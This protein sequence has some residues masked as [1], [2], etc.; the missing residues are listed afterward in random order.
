VPQSFVEWVEA[1]VLPLHQRNPTWERL[2]GRSAGG[3]LEE[4][5]RFQHAGRLWVVHGD[6][7]FAP[8]VRAYDAIRRGLVADPFVIERARTRD[9]LNLRHDLRERGPKHFYVYD[10]RPEVA[11]RL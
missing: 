9:C 2:D 11:G 5:G 4:L 3:N 8:I 6:T 7:R 1:E 10:A